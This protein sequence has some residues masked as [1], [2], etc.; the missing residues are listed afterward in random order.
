MHPNKLMVLQ[1]MTNIATIH[2]D[3]KSEGNRMDWWNNFNTISTDI[4][5]VLTVVTLMYAGFKWL[6]FAGKRV[7]FKG[8]RQ[9]F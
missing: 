3:S 9:I 2:T 5:N 8:Q 1:I 6:Q 7:I 4:V